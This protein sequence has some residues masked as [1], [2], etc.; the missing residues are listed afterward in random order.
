MLLR[1]WNSVQKAWE[2]LIQTARAK[3]E[4]K[5]LQLTLPQKFTT[6]SRS[7]SR[8]LHQARLSFLPR[9]RLDPPRISNS[10]PSYGHPDEDKNKQTNKQQPTW[11]Q[12]QTL[13]QET[14]KKARML[15]HSGGNSGLF[16]AS[17]EGVWDKRWRSNSQAYK[18]A[19]NFILVH[20]E[21]SL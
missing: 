11:Q 2:L 1:N 16:A 12:S 21:F 10:R 5:M 20:T 3:R 6:I 7:T 9:H 4:M 18:K 8:I 15:S 13:S 14:L 17:S 19:E